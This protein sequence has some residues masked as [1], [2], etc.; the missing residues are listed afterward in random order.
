ML[1]KH[2]EV[3]SALVKAWLVVSVCSLM[4]FLFSCQYLVLCSCCWA[5]SDE[6]AVVCFGGLTVRGFVNLRVQQQFSADPEDVYRLYMFSIFSR[7]YSG[8]ACAVGD[9]WH[10]IR[11][12]FLW[13]RCRGATSATYKFDLSSVPHMVTVLMRW[14]YIRS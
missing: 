14:G 3:P 12:I 9:V 1:E 2:F 10:N 11:M 8:A 7:S 5:T 6:C 13:M 4:Y